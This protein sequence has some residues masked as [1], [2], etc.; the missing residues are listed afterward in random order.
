MAWTNKE[1]EPEKLA[2]Y[3]WAV[4]AEEAKDITEK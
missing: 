2:T 3:K 1:I 4:C